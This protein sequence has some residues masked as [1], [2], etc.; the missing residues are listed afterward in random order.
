[1]R[2]LK[3]TF[4]GLGP[5]K[6]VD[7]PLED[8]PPDQVWAQFKELIAAYQVPAKGYV[9]RRAPHTSDER[10]D[11]DQLARFR[12]WEMTDPPDETGVGR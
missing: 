3:A 12:E 11:Y 2:V 7:A 6:E 8:E 9:A 4:I 5:Q 10:G 1:V